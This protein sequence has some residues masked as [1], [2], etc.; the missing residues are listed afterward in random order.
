LERLVIVILALLVA[1][2]AMRLPPA[3]L[4]PREAAIGAI[5]RRHGQDLRAIGDAHPRTG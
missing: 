3:G 4:S 2:Y 5:L 1:G